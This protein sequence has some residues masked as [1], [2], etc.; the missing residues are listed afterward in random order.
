M[1]RF[2][3]HLDKR[4]ARLLPLA[5]VLAVAVFFRL[6]SL[7]TVPPGLY[8]DEAVNGLD[9]LDVLHGNFPIF[10]ERNNGR[11]P[12][13][14]YL[15]AVSIWLLGQDPVAIRLVSA[16]FGILTVL[17]TY[18]LANEWF[19]YRVGL[20]S[21]AGLAISFWH[22]DLSRF[23][24]RAISTPLFI[25]LIL[26]FLWRALREENRA[27][28]LAAGIVTGLSLY[29]Y[30]TARLIPVLLLAILLAQCVASRRLLA[31]WRSLALST[32]VAVLIALPLVVYF[33]LHPDSFL[34]RT[35]QVSILNGAPDPT[36]GGES[37]TLVDT[38]VRT[39]GMFFVAG[40]T[41]WRLNF[42]GRPVFDP[43]SGALFVL[44]FLFISIN[45]RR[46]AADLRW[47]PRNVGVND[48]T[49]ALRLMPTAWLLLWFL[50]I[51]PAGIFS[52]ESPHFLRLVALAPATYI[53]AALGVCG[54]WSLVSGRLGARAGTGY[55]FLVLALLLTNAVMT[56]QDYFLNW[57]KREEV[58]WTFDT[59]HVEAARFLEGLAQ[60]GGQQSV[61]LFGMPAPTV[62]FS[63]PDY[64]DA[65]WMAENT[66]WLSLPADVDRDTIY[67]WPAKSP[68]RLVPKYFPDAEIHY[69]PN[70][71]SEEPA[72]TVYR[73]PK[74]KVNAAKTP[75]TYLRVV[76]GDAV[77]GDAIELVGEMVAPGALDEIQ[78]GES[79]SVDLL[80][81]HLA[82][83]RRDFK[84]S[85]QLNDD[86]RRPWA[87]E[88]MLAAS[89]SG[90]VTHSA[91]GWRKG[92]YLLTHHSITVPDDAPPISYELAI[93][94]GDAKTGS[95]MTPGNNLVGVSVP[96]GQT[97]VVRRKPSPLTDAEEPKNLVERDLVP[98]VHLVG[99]DFNGKPVKAGDGL[100]I[101]LVWR[102]TSP[103]GAD[104]VPE[105]VLTD[106]RGTVV[107]RQ[108]VSPAYD[109][110]PFSQWIIGDTVR[111]PRYLAVI[112]AAADGPAELKVLATEAGTGR[113]LGEMKLLSVSIEGWPRRFE[114]P[115]PQHRTDVDFDG[116]IR[117]LG[118]DIEPDVLAVDQELNLVLYWQAI[119]IPTQN[120]TVFTH[121]LDTAN[122]VIG[123]KD[124]QP[125]NGKY[126]T[127]GW[128]PGEVVRDTYT[129]KLTKRPDS[130][131]LPLEIGLYDAAAGKRLKVHGSGEDRIVL[132]EIEVQD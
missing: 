116:Q 2:S 26:Y 101:E 75:T 86:Q 73:L 38:M 12:L 104:V 22:V 44:G 29:T 4:V 64:R 90:W 88:D 48:R 129:L 71:A 45:L 53:I 123:Q 50:A 68:S 77:P 30:I 63:A 127:A 92:E 52:G 7:D 14:I 112:A 121:L 69:G 18:L 21:S 36:V 56:F 34:M 124:G 33:V 94:V 81:R 24:L 99:Y 76:F 126:P 78:P 46:H 105:L 83:S 100:G 61:T 43:V 128:L 8:N 114:L 62:V 54:L 1:K 5:A 87:R 67:V 49:E 37:A 82:D 35:G 66:N 93:S 122:T 59:N 60:A 42:A 72:F 28:F 118:Y 79:V 103:S 97:R 9:V 89:T 31:H 57:A 95:Q 58:Y 108:K 74:D 6:Y 17:A 132:G 106:N 13:F 20:L 23:G 85:M 96:I 3:L 119:S 113:R 25:L 107:G 40:D 102:L 115:S 39:A 130:R 41:N 11:E 117:L 98:G 91:Y 125:L 15:Q 109:R 47:L 110:Y 120:F 84:F 80:W 19:G 55:G 51:L 65:R 131:I 16:A 10:F 70:P 27:Y 32:S 111:D